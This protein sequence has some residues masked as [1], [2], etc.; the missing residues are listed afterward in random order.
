MKCTPHSPQNQRFPDCICTL[1]CPQSFQPAQWPNSCLED[2][3]ANFL[4]TADGRC[5]CN[6]PPT[7][8]GFAVVSRVLGLLLLA[9]AG[10]KLHGLA[11][12]PVGRSG[13]F[14]GPEWQVAALELEVLLGFWLLAGARPAGAWLGSILTFTFFAAISGYQTWVGQASCGCFGAVV[15]SPGHA[16]GLDLVVVFVLLIARPDF[17]SVHD[18]PRRGWIVALAP[19]GIGLAGIA[20]ILLILAGLA[21]AT[22]GS[23]D[24]ALAQLRGE[25]LS[26]QPR[27]ADVGRGRAGETREITLQ[28]RNWADEPIRIIGGTSDCSCVATEQL[29]IT[30]PAGESRSLTV[31]M[32]LPAKQGTF[33]RKAFLWTD[34]DH[35]RRLYFRLTGRSYK[36]SGAVVAAA[37]DDIHP[38]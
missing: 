32:R 34:D 9:A 33:T 19:L 14:S 4:E 24:A 2:R 31:K 17:S 6:P 20:A 16:L 27:L 15:V 28:L 30:I 1:P 21:T 12:D 23:V 8:I 35:N 22:A 37:S 29:P 38:K 18:E 3:S 36:P 13:I 7:K 10:L 26:I 25:R 11:I 5:A